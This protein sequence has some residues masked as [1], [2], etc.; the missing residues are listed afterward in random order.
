MVVLVK[1]LT[2]SL[3]FGGLTREI[4]GSHMLQMTIICG[5]PNQ[6]NQIGR[7]WVC[8]RLVFIIYLELF[9]TSSTNT[10]LLMVRTFRK[11]TRGWN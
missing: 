4:S 6:R 2:L 1:K 10:C 5:K 8:V 3:L 7:G 11:N 9:H